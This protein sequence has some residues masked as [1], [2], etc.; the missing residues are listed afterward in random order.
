[1]L[2]MVAWED[3]SG[4]AKASQEIAADFA[5]IGFAG[6]LNLLV[7]IIFFINPDLNGLV[8]FLVITLGGDL[9]DILLVV[10]ELRHVL[11]R[12]LASVIRRRRL[13]AIRRR[14]RAS[15]LYELDVAS[16]GDV[17]HVGVLVQVAS[18]TEDLIARGVVLGF[19]S[20]STGAKGT[21]MG[22]ITVGHVFTGQHVEVPTLLVRISR[23]L[24]GGFG[25]S[26][27]L[28]FLDASA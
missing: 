13:L 23:R 9:V 10:P 24:I 18:T 6:V 26:D 4:M 17:I 11:A 5:G 2:A 28:V 3:T 8:G 12:Y 20:R 1:M 15:R 22:H 16:A 14:L 25:H 21:A 27:A 7:L 19:V